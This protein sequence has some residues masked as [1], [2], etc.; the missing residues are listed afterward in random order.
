MR[1]LGRIALSLG[2]LASIGCAEGSGLD[3][4][5]YDMATVPVDPGGDDASLAYQ[6][7]GAD[8]GRTPADGGATTDAGPADGSGGDG[9]AEKVCVATNTCLDATDMGEVIGDMGRDSLSA[10][11]TTSQWFKV[12]GAERSSTATP[13]RI[14]ATLQSPP[15]ANFDLYVYVPRSDTRECSAVA[16]SS[17]STGTFDEVS[18]SWGEDEDLFGGNGENDSRTVTIEVRYVSGSC[19]PTAKWKLNVYGNQ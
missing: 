4:S 2:I 19:S 6:P 5:A 13:V 15:G 14:N 7:P 16:Q 8:A 17:T 3:P 10:Q 11:G 12:R 18:A 9:G 1:H